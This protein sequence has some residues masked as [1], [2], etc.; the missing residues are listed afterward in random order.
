MSK[1]LEKLKQKL[2]EH[3]EY[4]EFAQGLFE[5]AEG[6]R[7]FISEIRKQAQ[8]VDLEINDILAKAD[9]DIEEHKKLLEELEAKYADL[10][11]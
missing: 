9:H 8:A 11:K 5:Q 1:E 6:N 2:I 7:D 10:L 3:G 4:D